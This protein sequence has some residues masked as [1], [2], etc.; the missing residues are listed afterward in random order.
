MKDSKRFTSAARL[1][2]ASDIVK[3]HAIEWGI[4]YAEAG[5]IDTINIL[6]ATHAAMHRA[7]NSLSLMPD[8]L[9]VDGDRFKPFWNNRG[10][11]HEIVP[12][13]CICKGDNT[14]TSI[15][16]AGILAKVARDQWVADMC[17]ADPSLD[18]RYGLA[19]N[20]GYGTAQHMEGLSRYG[21]SEEHRLSFGPCRNATPVP[22]DEIGHNA[23]Q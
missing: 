2:E 6:H 5:E 15:A 23:E 9:L 16:A 19:Q 1:Q 4:A 13:V 11:V 17:A 22:P 20:K 18:E 14:Y 21:P 10:P 8:H 7:L 12:H 3:A